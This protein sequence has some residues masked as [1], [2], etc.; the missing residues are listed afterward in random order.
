MS[1]TMDK[2]V[3][4]CM[5]KT[6]TPQKRACEPVYLPPAIR[7]EELLKFEALCNLSYAPLPTATHLPVSSTDT[8]VP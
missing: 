6:C 7:G 2:I 8:M 4:K 5:N 3:L 1:G